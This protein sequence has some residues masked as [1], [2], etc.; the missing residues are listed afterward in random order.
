MSVK[1]KVFLGCGT[2]PADEKFNAWIEEKNRIGIDI[3]VLQLKYQQARYSD[4][5]ICILYEENRS[6]K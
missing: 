2:T 1:A 6:S 4:H 5:S 3:N